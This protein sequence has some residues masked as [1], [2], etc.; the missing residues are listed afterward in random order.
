M[1]TDLKE[2]HLAGNVRSVET[3][4]V[5]M[6]TKSYKLLPSG[7]EE[8]EDFGNPSKGSPSSPLL[9]EALKFDAA[10]KLIEDID[11]ERPLIEQESYRYVYTYNRRGLLVERVGYQENGSPDERTMYIYGP[12]GRRTEE[13]V[14][15]GDGRL[16]A[17]YEFDEHENF[18][19]PPT[20]KIL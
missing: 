12:G 2:Y 13:L 7:R 17:R 18:R 4:V 19:F 6:S 14:Y 5:D 20:I 16:Q 1:R 9:W 10:G 15:S 11:V 8:L 3:T